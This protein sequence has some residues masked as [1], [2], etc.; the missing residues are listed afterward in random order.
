M[1][2]AE[3][4]ADSLGDGTSL[5]VERPDEA[6]SRNRMKGL[7]QLSLDYFLCVPAPP[8]LPQTPHPQTLTLYISHY[9]QY[10]PIQSNGSVVRRR[11]V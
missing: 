7:R 2:E 1:L 5:T 9:R 8:I 10:S 3:S 11:G 6:K 4:L